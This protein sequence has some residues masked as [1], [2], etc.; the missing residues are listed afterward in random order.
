LEAGVK[1]QD[2]FSDLFE[3]EKFQRKDFRY[4]IEQYQIRPENLLVIG[5]NYDIDIVLA[6]K[7][8]CKTLHVPEMEEYR[9]NPI[10]KEKILSLII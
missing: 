4:I 9:E 8:G 3:M 2:F 10:D 1:W 5:D 6:K 7:Q